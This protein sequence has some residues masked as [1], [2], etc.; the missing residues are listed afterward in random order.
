M[1]EKMV[2]DKMRKKVVHILSEN[3]SV[4]AGSITDESHIYDDLG[5]DSLDAVEI[6]L[7]IEEAF[8]VEIPDAES[9]KIRQVKDIYSY[10]ETVL[11][12]PST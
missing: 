9:E 1:G 3:L 4:D 7:A 10:L 5:A 8:K 12:Q 11:N 2:T 6:V